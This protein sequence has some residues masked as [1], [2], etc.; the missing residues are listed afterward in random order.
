MRFVAAESK[1]NSS[2]FPHLHGL[3]VEASR[4]GMLRM[5]PLEHVLLARSCP[6]PS[7]EYLR[8]AGRSRTHLHA[9][10][11]L[12][13]PTT[14]LRG[15]RLAVGL[16]SDCDEAALSFVLIEEEI[17]CALKSACAIC[18]QYVSVTGAAHRR[19]RAAVVVRARRRCAAAAQPPRDDQGR[20]SRGR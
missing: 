11:P 10:A 8:P 18:E 5:Q 9:T 20:A 13:A 15:V 14:T 17:S 7:V 19:W 4:R 6:S 2:T 1:M 3:R 12:V 16:R